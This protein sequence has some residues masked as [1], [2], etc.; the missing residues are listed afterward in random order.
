MSVAESKLIGYQTIQCGVDCCM[1][2]VD[3]GTA[4]NMMSLRQERQWFGRFHLGSACE[5]GRARGRQVVN[6]QDPARNYAK[7]ADRR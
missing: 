6:E 7:P 5:G 1:G 2:A 4:H 3:A